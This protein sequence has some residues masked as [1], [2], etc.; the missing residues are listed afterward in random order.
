MAVGRLS[1]QW[2]WEILRSTY[3]EGVV[4]RV[5]LDDFSSLLV[6]PRSSRGAKGRLARRLYSKLE[7]LQRRGLITQVEGVIR[8]QGAP[9]K[10]TKDEA[11]PLLGPI[12]EKKLFLA[13]MAEDRNLE[14]QNSERLHAARWDFIARAT[15]TGWTLLQ[16]S[17]AL[18]ISTSMASEILERPPKV[19]RPCSE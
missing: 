7:Y 11:F 8:P 17:S 13:M 2:I 9:I 3:P 6:S 4:R 12:L 16:A 1:G 14:G 10:R 15:E 18:G 5:L 19:V